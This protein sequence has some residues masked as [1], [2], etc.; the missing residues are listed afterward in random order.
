MPVIVGGMV[1]E[2]RVRSLLES[3]RNVFL[4]DCGLPGDFGDG[5]ALLH[6]LGVV[7]VGRGVP[8]WSILIVHSSCLP[9]M[10]MLML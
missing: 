9:H 5:K 8:A 2:A 6:A 10:L 1:P 7:D 3:L 4:R